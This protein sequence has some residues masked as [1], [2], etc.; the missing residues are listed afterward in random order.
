[1]FSNVKPIIRIVLL[2][3]GNKFLSTDVEESSRRVRWLQPSEFSGVGGIC[4]LS[5][6]E[7]I[8]KVRLGE[9]GATITVLCGCCVRN[10]VQEF[11]DLIEPCLSC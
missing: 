3:S 4:E 9:T 1:M 11:L 6:T 8:P 5:D 7:S 2:C 10:L